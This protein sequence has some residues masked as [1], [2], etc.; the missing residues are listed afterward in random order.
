MAISVFEWRYVVKN[1]D[2]LVYLAAGWYEWR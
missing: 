2:T 1:G